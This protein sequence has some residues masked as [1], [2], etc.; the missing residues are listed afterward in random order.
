MLGMKGC[1]GETCP[2]SSVLCYKTI[3][4][5]KGT[6]TI[7]II[8]YYYI[9]A[10]N[11]EEISTKKIEA[12]NIVLNELPCN[13]GGSIVLHQIVISYTVKQRLCITFCSPIVLL[14]H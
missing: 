8:N 13:G 9:N 14:V 11:Y 4:L 1:I 7:L 12:L 10:V 6:F 2:P 3:C 5:K